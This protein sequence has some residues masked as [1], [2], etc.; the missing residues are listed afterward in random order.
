MKSIILKK[1]GTKVNKLRKQKGWSQE[2][3]AK[4]AKLH[5]TYIGS[6]ER[7]ERNVSL[8]NIEKIAKA[9]KIKVKFFFE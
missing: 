9:L 6:I 4:R 1:F 5:R 8:V 2:E 7:S 3:L